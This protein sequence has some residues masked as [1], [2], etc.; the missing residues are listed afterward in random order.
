MT[1]SSMV[2][3]VLTTDLIRGGS[4]FREGDEIDLP[5]AEAKR[6]LARNMA[7]ECA[8]LTPSAETASTSHKR[9]KRNGRIS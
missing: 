3:V 8:A 5:E 6:F 9:E 2:R 4:I 1:Q 7:I